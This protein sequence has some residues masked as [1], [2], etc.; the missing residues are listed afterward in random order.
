MILRPKQEVFVERCLA[1]L[2][3]RG[4]TLGVA[5]TG[6][7]KTLM[8]SAVAGRLI[9]GTDAK[10]L[11]LAH[12]D[13]LT[14]QN[15]DKFARIN[16]TLDSSV[17]DAGGKDW[18]GRAVFAMVQTLSRQANLAAMPA[19]DV[20]VVDEAHH[21]VAASYRRV[22]DQARE[23]NPD[24]KLLGVTATP[25]RGDGKG[26]REV[27]DNCADQIRLGELVA[28]GHLVPPRTFV[29]DVGVREDLSRVR[30]TV[31][32][33]D[34][35]EV[36]QVMARAPVTE[37]VVRHWKEKAQEAGSGGAATGNATKWRRTIVFCSTVAHAEHV[38]EAF[39]TEGVAAE[40]VTGET[41]A[42]ER[43]D[44]LARLD[45]GE[46]QVLVNVAVAT[47]GF[48]CQPVSCVMLLRPCS[49]KST[50]IQMIGRGLR[51]VDPELYS[52][53]VKTD[54]LVLDFG[55]SV[56]THGSLEQDVDLDD[57]LREE[58]GEAPT[59][60][61]PECT[62]EV[63][64]SVRECPFCGH[65]FEREGRPALETFAMTEIELLDRSP[66]RWVDLFGD[67]GALLAAG[68]D[69]WA[70]AFLWGGL[71]HA[72]GGGRD[73]PFR[74]LAIGDRAM[75]IASADDWLNANETTDAASKAKR[76]LREP[77]TAKQLAHLG[78][79]A[80]Q[81]FGLTRY[82][83]SCLLTFRWNRAAIRRAVFDALEGRA[84]A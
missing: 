71:W 43:A 45:S 3:G 54:C 75:A 1:A 8:L 58:E 29:V 74:R 23:R 46:T 18:A 78:E 64:L 24:L 33:F 32:D 38:A 22:I 25:S 51:P 82:R 20:M 48:D 10:A 55:T 53:V 6:S 70:G 15:R 73:L 27:F 84:A 77:A 26:L 9:S 81:D 17:V 4:N 37:Q 13:E 79:A 19:L 21:A 40:T 83:A 66:F 12:R 76:W 62:A 2:H 57:R 11:V 14:A 61:C 72:V 47:E 59:K 36:A 60:T 39:R 41:A 56:L 65:V 63:H 69:A 34:M 16:P 42:G 68:F 52:G 35:G 67:D 44:I 31:D 28:S 80:A 49:H 30:R 5:P 7:G 50:M